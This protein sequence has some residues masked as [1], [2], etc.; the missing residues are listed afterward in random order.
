MKKVSF[1]KSSN[2]YLLETFAWGMVLELENHN[3]FIDIS[4]PLPLIIYIHTKFDQSR[5]TS[6]FPKFHSDFTN[7]NSFGLKKQLCTEKDLYAHCCRKDHLD[8]SKII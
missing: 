6:Q 5:Q 4:I 3:R 1:E 2:F 7:I 8:P